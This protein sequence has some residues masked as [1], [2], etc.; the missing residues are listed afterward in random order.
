MMFLKIWSFWNSINITP[1]SIKDLISETHLLKFELAHLGQ[2]LRP[3][4][5]VTYDSYVTKVSKILFQLLGDPSSTP[6]LGRSAGEGKG[7][8]LQY[9][10]L[11]N[12]MGLYSPWD[13]KESDMTEQLSLTMCP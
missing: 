2:G 13:H 6:G 5:L 7:Y 4:D 11:E 3:Y 1:R 12:P 8:P 10:G 9:S